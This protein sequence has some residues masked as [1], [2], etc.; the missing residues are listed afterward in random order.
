MRCLYLFITLDPSVILCQIHIANCVLCTLSAPM[1][2][3]EWLQKDFNVVEHPLIMLNLLQPK[4]IPDAI[5]G[6]CLK[7]RES[8]RKGEPEELVHCSQCDNSGK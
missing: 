6:L 4:D 8:N 3:I 2:H 5:C 7:D 1:L